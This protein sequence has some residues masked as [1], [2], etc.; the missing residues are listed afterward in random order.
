MGAAKHCGGMKPTHTRRGRGAFT[1]V[2]MLVVVAII[3]ILAALLLPVLNQTQQRA[4]QVQCVNNL[5]ECGLAFHL[6]ANDHK[7]LFTTHVSTNDG[8]SMEFIAPGYQVMRPSLYNF[9]FQQFRPLGSEIVTPK[10]FACPGDLERWAATNFSQFNNWNLSYDIGLK[11]DASIPLALLAAD[12]SMGTC[13]IGNITG[14]IGH[15]PPPTNL[16]KY[17]TA[18][19]AKNHGQNGNVLF[20]DGHV[21]EYNKR[22]N[23]IA[24]TRAEDV[25]CPTVDP[26]APTLTQFAPSV[27][28]NHSGT[29]PNNPS[30]S[31][32]PPGFPTATGPRVPAGAAPSAQNKMPDSPQVLKSV[33][34]GGAQLH[35]SQASTPDLIST[36]PNPATKPAPA[37]ARLNTTRPAVAALVTN[38]PEYSQQLVQA[39]R[40]SVAATQWLLWL[41]L[42]ML[43]LILL[44]RWL[45][46][47]WRHRKIK[48]RFNQ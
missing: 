30:P 24:E 9:S 32:V 39:V 47:R 14:S 11:A 25:M 10:L 45:D 28:A 22:I 37:P 12:R 23:L 3:G 29:A 6:F 36:G 7:G 17:W 2:E 21:R 4:K 44:A 33:S 35:F 48:K 19:G 41:L 16:F 42:L 31:Y 18:W 26:S 46:R 43:L 20:P 34:A 13:P 1:L 27:P 15:V 38:E 8:G 40:E 5:R